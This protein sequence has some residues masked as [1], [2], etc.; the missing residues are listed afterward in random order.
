MV[1]TT[2]AFPQSRDVVKAAWWKHK[3]TRQGWAEERIHEQRKY[4]VESNG[5][6]ARGRLDLPLNAHATK[7][8]R[9]KDTFWDDISIT[10][11]GVLET[12]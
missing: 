7:K 5:H 11:V 12:W 6:C 8:G 3:G 10:V 2:P 4:R 1:R 9:R